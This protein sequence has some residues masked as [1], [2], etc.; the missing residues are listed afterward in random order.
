MVANKSS[1]KLKP[2][3]FDDLPVLKRKWQAAVRPGEKLPRYEDV[4]LGSLGRL[5]D[6]IVLL[7]DTSEALEVS[8]TGRYIQQWLNDER[9]D[10]PLSALSPDCATALAESAAGALRNNR[11]HL[12]LAHCVRDGMVRTYDVLALPTASRWGGTLVGTYVNERSVQ[13]NLLD[14]I[15]TNTEEGVLSL[16]TLRDFSQKASDLQIVHHNQAAS[17]LLKVP[18]ESLQWRRLSEGGN[19]LCSREVTDRLLEIVERGGRDQFEIDSDDR[20]LRLGA[21]ALGDMLSLTIS[22]VTALKRREASFRLLFDNNP[23]PMWVFDVE[24]TRFL[25]INDAAVQYYGYS[26]ARF[27]SMKLQ[28]IWPQDEWSSHTQAL[29]QIGGSHYSGRNWRHLKADG[30]EI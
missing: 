29:Q 5:A 22:D 9:W 16:A 15:F 17:A 19:L 24:T 21:T 18:S 25:N 11:P 28:E 2:E 14:A 1:R 3:M 6:H 23:M 30:S 10:I 4:M 27:L 20:N 12:A 8:R 7:K 26:R 13:Y